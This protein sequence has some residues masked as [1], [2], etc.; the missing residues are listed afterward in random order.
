M[1]VETPSLPLGGSPTYVSS[2][3]ESYRY[4]DSCIIGGNVHRLLKAVLLVM[5]FVLL[6]SEA[7]SQAI[8]IV[9]VSGRLPQGN[10]RVFARDTLYQITGYYVV[11]GTLLIEPGTTVEFIP[12]A[13]LI[14]SAG[15]RIIADGDIDAIWNR[16]TSG[17]GAFPNRYCDID[18]MR[19][20][21]V[22]SGKPE[23]TLSSPNHM[24]Y[25]P[26]LILYHANGRSRCATDPNLRNVPYRRDVLRAP[27]TF[28]GRPV[29]QFSPEWG[30]IV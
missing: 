13:R 2:S 5:T 15:G 25:A 12:N 14:D 27:I 26:L 6:G 16:N 4:S 19:S 7:Y 20:N 11:S 1:N 29:N 22:T 30:H 24:D 28:R 17:V 10:Y 3:H 18:Y 9:Q 21:V 23:I 8:P